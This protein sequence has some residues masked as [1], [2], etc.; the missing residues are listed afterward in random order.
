MKIIR[1]TN[2]EGLDYITPHVP[3]SEARTPEEFIDLFRRVMVERPEDCFVSLAFD[4]LGAGTDDEQVDVKAFLIASV[5]A[6]GNYVFIWHAWRKPEEEDKSLSDK[7]FY[8]LVVWTHSLGITRIKC[9]TGREAAAFERRW[10]FETEAKILRYDIPDNFEETLVT[11]MRRSVS[12]GR[13][14]PGRRDSL[15]SQSSTEER[16]GRPGQV[17]D[18][19]DRSTGASL[20]GGHSGAADS[21][22][23][24][25]EGASG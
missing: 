16:S 3:E 13:Q 7:L 1:L 24:K 8:R 14:Q 9:E 22:A 5:H 23:G 19:T 4:V 11:N 20:R 2:P 21:G 12:D 6:S 18:S 10:G 17:P 15:E 25:S